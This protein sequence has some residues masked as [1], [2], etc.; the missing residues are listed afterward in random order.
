MKPKF[1]I[2]CSSTITVVS[3]VTTDTPRV[4]LSMYCSNA[5]EI[6]LSNSD[7]C[8]YLFCV[9][10]S[11][12][13]YKKNQ[14]NRSQFSSYLLKI[15]QKKKNTLYYNHF[16]INCLSKNSGL[17]VSLSKR[18]QSYVM[19]PDC[20]SKSISFIFSCVKLFQS[21][22]QACRLSCRCDLGIRP[23]I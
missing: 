7:W 6:S 1:Q 18:I 14:A 9:I 20:T 16:I 4:L 19:S 5:I 17:N 15:L 13:D 11:E 12:P 21:C 10:C 23:H 22:F 8:S 2:T 3:R